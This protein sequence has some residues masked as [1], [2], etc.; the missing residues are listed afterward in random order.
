[1]K[2]EFKIA[3]AKED[4]IKKNNCS[5]CLNGIEIKMAS[6]L[7]SVVEFK[8]KHLCRYSLKFPKCRWLKNGFNYK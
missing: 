5:I 6:V 1:M 2:L 4:F 8:D 7:N 3:K